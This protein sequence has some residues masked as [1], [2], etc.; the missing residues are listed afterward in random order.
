MPMEYT[1]S[2]MNQTIKDLA[3]FMIQLAAKSFQ[4]VGSLCYDANGDIIVGP[5]HTRHH[6]ILR[7]AGLGSYKTSAQCKLAQVEYLMGLV[8][9]RKLQ[10]DL[11]WTRKRQLDPVWMYVLL[12]EARDI[13]NGS[14]EMNLDQPTFLRHGDDHLDQLLVTDEGRLTAVLDW[15][16]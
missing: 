1:W 14:E 8:R 4:G 16:L 3:Q 7:G 12:L 15:E 9:G 2:M 10:W 6:F 13:I 5:L 11:R